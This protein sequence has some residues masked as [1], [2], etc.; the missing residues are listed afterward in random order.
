[1]T[2]GFGF[3]L[4]ALSRRRSGPGFELRISDLSDYQSDYESDYDL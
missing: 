1:M 2:S 3:P 4:A